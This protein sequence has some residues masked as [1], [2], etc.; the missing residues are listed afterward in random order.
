MP[1]F[2]FQAR[3]KSGQRISGTR[4]ASDQQAVLNEL[5]AEGLYV[6][7][8]VPIGSGRV[9]S[10]TPAPRPPVAAPPPVSASPPVSALTPAAPLA[11][12][13]VTAQP[14]ALDPNG[15]PPPTGFRFQ[16]ATSA[17]PP[18]PAQSPA[19]QPP[20]AGPVANGGP[21]ARPTGTPRPAGPPRPA[22]TQAVA[23]PAWQTPGIQRPETSEQAVGAPVNG[24]APTERP[25][26][27]RL[28][29]PAQPPLVLNGEAGR[30]TGTVPRPTAAQAP[31]P[32]NF[33]LHAN[34]RDMSLFFSQMHAMLH[35]GTSVSQALDTMGRH[36]A[37]KA[38]A[39]ACRDMGLRTSRGQP[40]SE[41]MNAYPGIFS[42]LMIG[43]VGAGEL[44]G[45]LDRMCKR[46][47]E[48]CARDY[49]IQQ[50]IKRE[51]WY[52]KLII[53]MSFLIPSLVPVIVAMMINTGGS[54]LRIWFD[55][56]RVPLFVGI[57]IYVVL[58]LNSRFMPLATRSGGIRYGIDFVKLALPIMG[59]TVRALSTAKFCRSLGALQAAGAGWNRTIGMAANACGNAVIA[60]RAR[61]I[62]PA[63]ERGQS[64][65]VA[66]AS[67]HFLPGIAEQ[68]LRTGEESGD[69]ETQLDK[70]A[71]FL[72][73]DAETTIKQSVVV[74]G[75]LALLL[76]GLRIGI[77]VIS[78]YTGYFNG[79]MNAGEG[80]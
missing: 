56:I 55:E 46:L 22:R 79:V 29:G 67:Q 71:D 70:V 42:E 2:A 49:E 4:D 63:I 35:A 16:P 48:Y 74:L 32:R 77:Q 34:S 73:A 50:T 62:L 17:P 25:P 38:L 61:A 51:T 3:D 57:I 43:M 8:L 28:A 39:Q 58:K 76:V 47:S 53:V 44:G 9:A 10:A 7:Q 65:S 30:L 75:I 40:W 41:T 27:A 11:A 36:S 15:A 52:P 24:G 45:F 31:E 13:P 23:Q 12:A 69:I 1:T 64:L 37:N 54:P 72:E 6:T 66:L 5:R 80:G 26:T 18:A 19:A 78:F 14:P 33:F 68:M 21:A 60:E 59:K 20:S